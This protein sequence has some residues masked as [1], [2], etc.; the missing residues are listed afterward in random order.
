[1]VSG[2]KG[3]SVFLRRFRGL[4]APA[5]S[6]L[7]LFAG[8]EDAASTA[9]LETGATFAP[10]SETLQSFLARFSLF[11]RKRQRAR[12][13]PPIEREGSMQTLRPS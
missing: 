1:M 12:L 13:E 5:P 11:Q 4:K 8:G 7:W 10:P 3:R 2:P 9:G 6:V